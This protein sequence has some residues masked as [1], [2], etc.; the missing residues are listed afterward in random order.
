MANRIT[1]RKI[2]NYVPMLL[3]AIAVSLFDKVN[4]DQV[5]KEKFPD[6]IIDFLQS[7]GKKFL[8][9]AT[10][11]IQEPVVRD[12]LYNLV[13]ISKLNS[14]L[15]S[16]VLI[17]KDINTT[18][19]FHTDTLILVTSSNSKKWENYIEILIGTKIMSSLIICIGKSHK[20]SFENMTTSLQN[21]SRSSF[22]YWI[23]VEGTG[24]EVV[25]MKNIISMKNSKKIISNKI[26][27]DIFGRAIFEKDMQG[28]H[29][30]CTTLSWLPYFELGNC[31]GE[32]KTNCKGV[33]YLADVMNIFA[34]RYNFTWSCDAEP[35]ENWG[36]VQP[37][38]GPRNENGTWGGVIGLVTEGSYHMCVSIFANFLW[39]REMFD[40]V[41]IGAGGPFLIAYLPQSSNFDF[42][43]FIRP[44][45]NDSWTVILI[46][47]TFIITTALLGHHFGGNINRNRNEERIKF[48]GINLVN[49]IGW[50]FFIIVINGYYDGALT[51]FFA[52]ENA[53]GFASE[54]DLLKD[55]DWTYNLREG[56]ITFVI[57]RAESGNELYQKKADL[58]EQNPDKYLFKSIS[59]GI[60]R[61]KSG[62]VAIQLD[63]KSLR[64]FYKKNQMET[65][66][67][68]IVARPNDNTENFILT[69]NSPLTPIFAAGSLQ[70]YETGL[71]KILEEKWMGKK[72]E[73]KV[74]NRL[75]TVVL[76]LGQVILMFFLLGSAIAV[77][78]IILGVEYLWN[79]I[80]K[81][82]L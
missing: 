47:V 6:A 57:N 66:P 73:S 8:N 13:Q 38:S 81:Y 20:Q 9:F 7:N 40:F 63:G 78:I 64:Q 59:E 42:W 5:S 15:R 53:V 31:Q 58:I 77:S 3:I 60:E 32:K 54:S 2:Y 10:M 11:D 43:L 61:M 23:G 71:M 35:D 27:F 50:L 55:P 39:R 48:K 18:H 4:C 37:I 79:Q 80:L 51:S 41:K 68:T 75:H 65:R 21:K 36:H 1:F 19:R 56:E 52:D 28:I 12:A 82:A 62:R 33:G 25:D 45:S 24:L 17:A 22:F 72:L 29:I 46:I 49:I 67:N 26:K 34:S 30:N 69:K 76:D 14:K 70:L 44:F 16:R 74:S